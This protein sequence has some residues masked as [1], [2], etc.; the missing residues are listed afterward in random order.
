MLGCGESL[1][2]AYISRK[3]LTYSNDVNFAFMHLTA[4]ANQIKR[5]INELLFTILSYT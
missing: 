2:S 5:A 4:T 1:R 3:L